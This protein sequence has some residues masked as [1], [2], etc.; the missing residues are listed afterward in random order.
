MPV[1]WSARSPCLFR[2]TPPVRRA[3]AAGLRF[4]LT[5][6]MWCLKAMPET[7]CLAIPTTLEIFSSR[8][9]RAVPSG[10]SRRMP[11]ARRRTTTATT[12]RSPPTSVTSCSK[13][14]PAT[15]SLAIPMA[16]MTSLSRICKPAA[17]SAFLPVAATRRQTL[18]AT[19]LRSPLTA[20]TSC[21]RAIPVIWFRATTVEDPTSSSRICR[22]A[23]SSAYLPPLAACRKLR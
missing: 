17:S 6:A 18:V 3:V 8:T 14:M 11:V 23:R 9:C 4:P 10:V 22:L 7:W 20:V 16:T 15:W 5:V 21:S 12:P 1:T 13:A 19:M 2:P